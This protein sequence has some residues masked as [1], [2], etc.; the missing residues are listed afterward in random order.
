M[1]RRSVLTFGLCAMALMATR[2]AHAADASPASLVA[3]ADA[4]RLPAIEGGV[5]MVM[6]LTDGEGAKRETDRIS[7]VARGDNSLVQM[8]DGGQ[9]GMKVLSS[10]QAL[11][12]YMPNTRRAMRLTPLQRMRGQANVGDIARLR[13]ADDYEAAL[14]PQASVTAEGKDCWALVLTA[15]SPAA[16][17]ATVHL[18]VSK[19]TGAPVSAD[20]LVAS[21]RRLKTVIYGPVVTLYGRRMIATTTYVD[22]V[23]A[24]LRT[25]VELLSVE[26]ST[27]PSG[28]FRPEAL[29]TDF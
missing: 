13:F 15:K 1:D 29:P 19:A 17:Y 20:M 9:R 4:L 10:H 27:A 7:V 3:Q 11:W 24:K 2:P 23:N 14:S 22:G 18:R 12:I 25:T 5:K 6:T 28:M 8:L 21:G 16:T 26:R